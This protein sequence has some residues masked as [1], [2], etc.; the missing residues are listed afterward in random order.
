[1]GIMRFVKRY[2]SRC[3]I[4]SSAAFSLDQVCRFVRE[5]ED[6]S[7]EALASFASGNPPIPVRG[8]SEA[9]TR[10]AAVPGGD[11]SPPTRRKRTSEVAALSAPP[12]Q[13]K[14]AA[15]QALH[16]GPTVTRS[17][18]G[19]ANPPCPPVAPPLKTGK[20]MAPV[21]HPSRGSLHHITPCAGNRG[22]WGDKI[23][24]H[25]LK[26]T[27]ASPLPPTD[28]ARICHAAMHAR[29]LDS[30]VVLQRRDISVKGL[31]VDDGCVLRR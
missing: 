24:R 25:S 6:M 28:H 7:A 9:V 17:R 11:P 15:S 10:T 2:T 14:T 4:A 21:N 30:S 22:V 29:L 31:A 16:L 23:C 5:S 18:P 20:P 13:G 12:L 26:D 1:M 27:L 3:R 19:P 8:A